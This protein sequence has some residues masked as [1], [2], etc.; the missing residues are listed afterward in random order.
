M[1]K[2]LDAL[3]GLVGDAAGLGRRRVRAR[4]VRPEGLIQG[5]ER[6]GLHRHDTRRAGQLRPRIRSKLLGR[7]GQVVRPGRAAQPAEHSRAL[8]LADHRS[9][10]H[11]RRVRSWAGCRTRAT[12]STKLARRSVEKQIETLTTA[13]NDIEQLTLGWRSTLDAKSAH[14]DLNVRP[15]PAARLG[16]AIGAGAETAPRTSP[17]S[18]CPTRRLRSTLTAKIDKEN[19]EQ[20]WRHW[21][22]LARGA[23]EH[24]DAERN[25][26]R[27]QPARSWPRK[28]SARCSTPFKPRS[29]AARSTP[30][31]R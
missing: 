21:P 1:K 5:E 10:A 7:H 12:T 9:V 31:P 8:S 17:A 23:L 15:L 30:A 25:A 2:L 4:P 16:Q 24:I 29:K 22:R 3:A 20:F 18:W 26:D 6:V 14:I 13:I 28:W 11:G 19:A 27:R